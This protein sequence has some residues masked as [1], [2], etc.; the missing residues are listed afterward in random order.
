VLVSYYRLGRTV[1]SVVQEYGEL[2]DGESTA[3]FDD[4]YNALTAAYERVNAAG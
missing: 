2:S 1:I 4:T 3:F